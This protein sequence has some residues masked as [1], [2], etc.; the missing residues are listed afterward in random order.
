MTCETNTNKQIQRC[1][2]VVELWP[3]DDTIKVSQYALPV[4]VH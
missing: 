1:R 2:F 3:G 4:P